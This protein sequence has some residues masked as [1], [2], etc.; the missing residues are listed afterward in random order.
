MSRRLRTYSRSASSPPREVWNELRLDIDRK[1]FLSRQP[2]DALTDSLMSPAVF[3]FSF[4]TARWIRSKQFWLVGQRTGKITNPRIGCA[5]ADF[6]DQEAGCHLARSGHQL[7]RWAR[8]V[9]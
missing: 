7:Q 5:A 1:E 4:W 2:L 6:A 9:A 8:H 3:L